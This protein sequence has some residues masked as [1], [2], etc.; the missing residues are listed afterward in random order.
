MPEYRLI[1]N[2]ANAYRSSGNYE[3]AIEINQKILQ[4]Q[5]NQICP[6]LQLAVTFMLMG[7]DEEAKHHAAEAMRIDP[8]FSLERCSKILLWKNCEE[9][10]RVIDWR[11]F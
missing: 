11:A 1:Q 2:F 6:H 7:R 8:K 5:P 10:D 3:K 4:K 9:A